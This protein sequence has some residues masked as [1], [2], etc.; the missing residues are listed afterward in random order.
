MSK[1]S[2]QKKEGREQ[3]AKNLE[4]CVILKVRMY[5]SPNPAPPEVSGEGNQAACCKERGNS[6]LCHPAAHPGLLVE[7][8][9]L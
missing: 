6:L 5:S 7:A 1:N 8:G 4:N 2:T 9:G 3:L